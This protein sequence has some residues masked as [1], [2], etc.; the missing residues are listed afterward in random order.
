MPQQFIFDCPECDT[1]VTVGTEIRTEIL[2]HGCVLCETA[3]S[4]D[5]FSQP[6]KHQ[7]R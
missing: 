2:E 5:A 7:R 4:A 6:E 3:V 1:V